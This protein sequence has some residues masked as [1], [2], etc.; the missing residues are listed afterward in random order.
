[1]TAAPEL[2][3]CELCGQR[4]DPD[5]PWVMAQARQI[6]YGSPCPTPKEPS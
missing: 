3:I 1:M 6:L 4:H 5:E 2:Q